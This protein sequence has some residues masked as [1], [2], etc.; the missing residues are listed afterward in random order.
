MGIPRERGH[1]SYDRVA[2]EGVSYGDQTHAPWYETDLGS[3]ACYATYWLLLRQT[4]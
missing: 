3:N 1:K 2:G 4:I